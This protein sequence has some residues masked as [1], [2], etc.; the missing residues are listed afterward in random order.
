M[1]EAGLTA[2]FPSGTIGEAGD[3]VVDSTYI[4]V[5][6]CEPDG[7]EIVPEGVPLA[8]GECDAVEGGKGD[9]DRLDRGVSIAAPLFVLV[10]LV[11]VDFLPVDRRLA[12]AALSS[13]PSSSA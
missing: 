2:P 9:R 13:S 6:I 1:S 8:A 7:G 10:M 5:W 11:W 12:G 4:G 3:R